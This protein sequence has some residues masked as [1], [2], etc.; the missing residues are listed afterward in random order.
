M[1][2]MMNHGWMFKKLVLG[3]LQTACLFGTITGS[4]RRRSACRP[5]EEV[6]LNI[7]SNSAHGEGAH[8]IDHRR[9]LR[10]VEAQGRMALHTSRPVGPLDVLDGGGCA[11]ARRNGLWSGC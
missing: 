2:Q 7:S 10:L 11:A 9:S 6:F 8:G 1:R 5:Q 3:P 4:T